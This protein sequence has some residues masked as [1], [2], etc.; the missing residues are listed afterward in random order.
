[1]ING[2]NILINVIELSILSTTSWPT[3]KTP[4]FSH[5]QLDYVELGHENKVEKFWKGMQTIFLEKAIYPTCNTEEVM[6]TPGS[7]FH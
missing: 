2:P 6:S 1:M 4:S 3:R 5:V 7:S